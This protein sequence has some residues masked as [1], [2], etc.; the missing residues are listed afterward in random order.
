D[1]NQSV[2]LKH[3]FFASQAVV[4]SIR[5]AGGGTIINMSS[6]AFNLNMGCFPAYA[7]AKAAVVGLTKSLPGRMQ[8]TRM[9]S[10]PSL[11]A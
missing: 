2:N 11:P 9:F 7:A 8:L 4:P 3:V 1:N 5:V 6:I 10:G